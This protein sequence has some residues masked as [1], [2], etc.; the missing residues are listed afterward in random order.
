MIDGVS[1]DNTNLV[2][3]PD[4]NAKVSKNIN[5]K[6]PDTTNDDTLGIIKTNMEN[7]VRNN[8]INDTISDAINDAV[9]DTVND[10]VNDTI[11]NA[12]NDLLSDTVSDTVRQRLILEI[13]Q[14]KN[15]PG[16]KNRTLVEIFEVSG[17]TIKRDMQKIREFVRFVPPQKTGGYYLTTKLKDCLDKNK[18]FKF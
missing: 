14:V 15:K 7:Y 11:S 8:K 12:V 18:K 2:S 1:S 17:V 10:T 9:S 5:C 3:E 4:N 6:I 13:L 16:I